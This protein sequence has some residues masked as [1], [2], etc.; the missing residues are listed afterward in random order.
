MAISDISN[1]FHSIQQYKQPNSDISEQF[2]WLWRWYRGLIIFI[3]NQEWIFSLKILNAD[4]I[5]CGESVFVIWKI[6]MI[7]FFYCYSLIVVVVIIVECIESNAHDW[8]IILCISA[9][10]MA[11]NVSNTT[12]IHTYKELFSPSARRLSIKLCGFL[13]FLS[14]HLSHTLSK[15]LSHLL[16]RFFGFV[17]AD[18]ICC[19]LLLG[20]FSLC[21]MN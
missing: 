1:I 18:P 3:P 12:N 15:H 10:W 7:F 4:L 2:V 21:T 6:A 19:S 9:M 8:R 5:A 11:Y 16:I 17:V 20:L 13:Q 14:L